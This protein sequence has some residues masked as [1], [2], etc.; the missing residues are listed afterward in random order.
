MGQRES[1]TSPG[2]MRVSN[3]VLTRCQNYM[4][5][6]GGDRAVTGAPLSTKVSSAFRST[7]HVLD[8]AQ[9]GPSFCRRRRTGVVG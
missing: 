4:S 2:N 8:S 9:I 1:R 7:V 3:G 6:V 5:C